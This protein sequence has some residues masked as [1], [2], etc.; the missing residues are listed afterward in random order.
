[1]DN[2]KANQSNV[3]LS[4]V[5]D[6]F[7][8][9]ENLAHKPDMVVGESNR[10][11]NAAPTVSNARSDLIPLVGSSIVHYTSFIVCRRFLKNVARVE[12]ID[13]NS[14]YGIGALC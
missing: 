13:R 2:A 7:S 14:I 3:I 10:A 1:M 11:N 9:C 4:G 5:S 8:C 12:E 6:D